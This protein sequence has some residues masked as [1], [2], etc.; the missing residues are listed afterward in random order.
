MVTN[1]DA[2]ARNVLVN[3]YLRYRFAA[4]SNMTHEEF[5]QACQRLARRWHSLSELHR[6]QLVSPEVCGKAFGSQFRIIRRTAEAAH[7]WSVEEGDGQL[8][9]ISRG[10]TPC[11]EHRVDYILAGLG[12]EDAEKEPPAE[13]ERSS[14]RR[15]EF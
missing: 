13:P 10:W 15:L 1:I 9:W 3:A 2:L 8:P 4:A 6:W 12:A 7:R 11:N 14:R 5:Q